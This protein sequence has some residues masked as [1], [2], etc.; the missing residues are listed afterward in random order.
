MEVEENNRKLVMGVNRYLQSVV[1]AVEVL[2]EG[3]Q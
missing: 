3:K 1:L 2:V